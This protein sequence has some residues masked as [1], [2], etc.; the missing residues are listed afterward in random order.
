MDKTCTAQQHFTY[1]TFLRKLY[2][3]QKPLPVIS[4]SPLP[5]KLHSFKLAKIEKEK[6]I[7]DE[8]TKRY[9]RGDMDNVGFFGSEFY[10]KSSMKFEE[11]G[12]F[13]SHHQQKLILIDGAPGVGKTT[14]SWEFCRKWGN[15]EILQ[16]H[17]LLL[18]LPL[19]DNNLK[20]AKTLAGLFYHPNKELQQAVV[21][22]ITSNQG[23]RVAIWLDALDEL[24]HE[25]REKA[26]VFLDL[27]MVE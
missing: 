18:L 20:K 14:F 12:T 9:L 23:Q 17:F 8:F 1:S 6:V 24:D 10:K 13:S 5:Q 11:V 27:S 15:G 4:S 2:T 3:S 26:S 19:R 16:D 21:Q 25:P 22:E 7:A